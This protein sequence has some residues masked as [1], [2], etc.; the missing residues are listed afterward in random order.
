[1]ARP[2]KTVDGETTIEILSDGVFIAEDDR[3]DKG[4]KATVPADIA[5]ILIERGHGKSV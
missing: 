1:M 3:R 2:K 5:E 4:D